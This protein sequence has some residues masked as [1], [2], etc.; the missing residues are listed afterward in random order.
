MKAPRAGAL[1][2]LLTFLAACTRDG[3]APSDRPILV[4]ATDLVG[5]AAPSP[6]P[7]GQFNIPEITAS[8][9]ALLDVEGDGDLDIYLICHP[10]PGSPGAPAPNR[11]FRQEMPG[12]F[13]EVP[14]AAGLDDGGYGNGAA[15]GDADGDGDIDVYVC[16]LGKDS[17]HLNRGNGTF[18]DGTRISGIVEDGWSTAA[19]FLDH[20]RDGDLDLYVVHYLAD[21]PTL[22]CRTRQGER[23]DYCGPARFQSVADRL[24]RNEGGG[25]FIDVSVQSGI[26]Q[27]RAGLAVACADVTGDGW[28][29]IYVANDRQPNTLHV[30]RRDGTFADEALERGAALSGLGEPEASM[31]VAIGDV[32]GDSFLDILVTNL[33]GETSTLYLAS[34]P[35]TFEDSSASAGLGAATLELT[36]WGCGF[37]DLDNDGDLDLPL[38]NGKIARGAVPPGAAL[39]PFWNDY[40]E[41]NSLFINEGGRFIDASRRAGTFASEPGLHRALAFG[42]WDR[43]GDVD[44]VTSDL[45]NRLRLFRNDAPAGNHWLRVRALTGN[46]DALGAL[47]RIEAGGIRQVR[48]LIT[49][50]SYAASSE[51]VAHFGLGL[52][53]KVDVLEVAWPDGTVERFPPQDVD[54]LVLL[55]EGEGVAV[56]G[57]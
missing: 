35:G 3:G 38:M 8:G 33:V 14:G 31:G 5:V 47:V 49:S 22:V 32:N 19:A 6:W 20:D 55:R 34:Q 16:N 12:R 50:Y 39:G 46:R 45:S 2:V 13:V 24:Y 4:E 53:R 40:A 11:L 30:N 52:A 15:V 57:K 43:D 18:V 7:D 9:V 1:A 37:A 17:L 54:R 48:P 27:A 26:V 51:P 56:Q 23:R 25:R 10:P 41:R 29:D 36:S 21:D 44:F 42:D 28:V